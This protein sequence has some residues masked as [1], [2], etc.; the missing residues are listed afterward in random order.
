MIVGMFNNGYYH[1]LGGL[2]HFGG[3][4]YMNDHVV[5]SIGLDVLIDARVGI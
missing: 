1:W 4:R 5:G 2:Y 3:I